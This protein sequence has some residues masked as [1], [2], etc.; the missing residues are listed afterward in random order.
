MHI[1]EANNATCFWA[2]EMLGIITFQ[3]VAAPVCRNALNGFNGTV[4]AYGQTGSG[5]THTSLVIY[6]ITIFILHK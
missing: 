4:F 5:K 6:N 1:A 2:Q 3:T